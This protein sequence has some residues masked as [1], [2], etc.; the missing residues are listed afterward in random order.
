MKS[1]TRR[2]L[3]IGGTVAAAAIVGGLHY[4]TDKFD[5]VITRWWS[6][7]FTTPVIAEGAKS[8]DEAREASRLNSLEVA[9]EGIVMLKNKDDFLPRDP[10][11]VALLGFAAMNPVYMG[12]G[13][14]AQGDGSTEKIDFYKAFENAGYT[15]DSTMKAYYEGG[16]SRT[17][18]TNQFVMNGSDYNISDYPVDDYRS[19]LEAAAS[20]SKD[21]AIIV[22]S[23]CGGEGGDLPIDMR[24]Y[25]NGDAGE[26]YLKLQ[27]TERELLD[28]AMENFDHVVV[29]LDSANAMQLD[30]L[31]DDRIDAAFWVG[32]PGNTGIEAVPK[33]MT[34]EVNPSG[35]LVDVFPYDTM[36]NPTYWT[37]TCGSYNNYDAF[38][39]GDEFD[40][41]VD[42]GMIW[43][44]ENVYM[45]YRY[46]ETAAA[47]KVIDY[48]TTVQ[49]PFGFG[50]SY[51]TFEWSIDA[52]RLGGTH[53]TIEID[54]VVKNTGKVAG[55]DV[56]QLYME[57]PY[58]SNGIEK[59]ARILMAFAKTK[60]LEP[61]EFETVTL[62]FDA[63]DIASYDQN[64]ERC[65]VA[66]KGDY[67]FHL[68]TDSHNDKEGVEPVKYTV[69]SQR[70][71]ND[72]GVGK[73]SSDFV[74]AENHFDIAS[75][76]DGNVGNTIPWMT[77]MDLAG[78]HP[79]K[80]MGGQHI[81]NMSISMGDEMVQY[82]LNSNGGS[83]VDFADDANY[84]CKSL[85]PVETEA[86]NGLTCADLAGYEAW[87]DPIWDQ[88]VNQMSVDD[89]DVL[90]CD[91]AYGT[92][93]IESIGKELETCA[94]GPAGVSTQNLNY[95]GHMFCGE[96]VTA[97][98]W[99][100]DLAY[101][102]GVC[103]GDECTAAGINGWYAPGADTHRT[104]FG[105]RCAEY[106][107]E[108][109]LLAGKICA[110]E[111]LGAQ[112]KGVSP[113]LKHFVLNDQDQGRG[114]MYT[115]CNEQALRE[116]YLKAFE[117]PMKAG[118]KGVMEAY[119]RIGPMECSCC[120]GL[121]TYVL[122]DEWGSH[123]LA[124][125]DG[126]GA[127]LR[128]SAGGFIIANL[129][130]TDKYEHP[131]IQLRA[132]CGMLLYT[133]GYDPAQGYGLSDRTKA[134]D[135]G[136]E[137]MHD[138]CKRIV[139]HYCNSNMMS[140]KR[141]YTPYWKYVL[142]GIDGVLGAGLLAGWIN[143]FRK[144][145]KEEE[146]QVMGDTYMSVD[147]RGN[148]L[149]IVDGRVF[150]RIGEKNTTAIACPSCGEVCVEASDMFCRKCGYKLAGLNKGTYMADVADIDEPAEEVIE[151][152][153]EAAEETVEEFIE[154]PVEEIAEAVEDKADE[155]VAA[156]EDK[157]DEVVAEAAEAVEETAAHFATEVEEAAEEVAEEI[158]EEAAE[159]TAE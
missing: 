112:S 61:G 141:D 26:H 32:A 51:T 10:G 78:T 108:D 31:D 158:A 43:Y 74:V 126:Y 115:W 139:Y 94:D 28:F 92:P 109:P 104:P 127:G 155:V 100:V 24:G 130:N 56:V 29:M 62:S 66:D 4:Y 128:D 101:E 145:N 152:A 13:S 159:E 68:Q 156:V 14:V 1:T 81:K 71:F 114:G 75:Q 121:N 42:G 99:N 21:L 35:H 41:K 76:G 39:G 47:E 37:C 6:G 50:L 134:S 105:G 149:P 144:K 107:A 133:G 116:I 102:M 87:D 30:F 53:E 154:T 27:T 54:V 16:G 63:D 88:L 57:P 11:K 120:K 85:I 147:R 110:A 40:N 9:S 5:T 77:R 132:G 46:Y 19:E 148:E 91:C 17:N 7:T 118:C 33:L 69:G 124:L 122:Q 15:V 113:Y 137:M 38:D 98:T 70:V 96:P 93:A 138:M 60:L 55:K 58:I 72:T 45:G 80:T 153:V 12:A 23:R 83:D 106:Y 18:K 151:E 111:V 20:A 125:T 117:I 82:M 48:D 95:Y 150:M 123:P 131:D 79:E 143:H 103:L 44:P 84:V 3:L 140:T 8:A 2:N 73:R 65:Y 22:Y 129:M 52:T 49:F 34:G 90:I 67:L 157:A 59:P 136:I 135:K 36:S 146:Q 142:Y 25:T 64:V 97:A 119:P 86:D 89:M